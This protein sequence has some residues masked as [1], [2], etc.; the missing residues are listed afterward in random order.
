MNLIEKKKNIFEVDSKY[1][2][3]HCISS[4]FLNNKKAMT[5]GIAKKF[6][7]KYDIKNK[8]IN[9]CIIKNIIPNVGDVILVDNVFNLI[10]KYNYWDKPS[11]DSLE[12]SLINLKKLVIELNI[13]FLTMPRIVCGLDKLNWF[14]VKNMIQNIFNDLDMDILVCHDKGIL[15]TSYI[16]QLKNLPEDI[17]KVIIMRYLPKWLNT[18]NYKNIFIDKSFAPQEIDLN[19][20]LEDKDWDKFESNFNKS[21][22]ESNELNNSIN[23]LYNY[24]NCGK[25]IILLCCEK[26]YTK[27]HRSLIGKHII[28]KGLYWEEFKL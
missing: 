22:Y 26:D 1:Y 24:L 14:N 2:K 3:V 5:Q 16:S 28:K 6:I 8:L 19:T 21:I 15:Y 13:K 25:N 23:K 10:T 11:Y 20:Y 18:K 7:E 9:K 4:D 17:N 27:C 12:K